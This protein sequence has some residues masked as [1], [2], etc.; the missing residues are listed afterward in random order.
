VPGYA[1]ER[2]GTADAVPCLGLLFHSFKCSINL[3]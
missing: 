3:A 2:F 1:L